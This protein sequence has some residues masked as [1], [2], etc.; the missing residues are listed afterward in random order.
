M[1]PKAFD[2]QQALTGLWATIGFL[3]AFVLHEIA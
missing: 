1:I 3:V 2:E